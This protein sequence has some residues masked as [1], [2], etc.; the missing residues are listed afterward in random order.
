MSTGGIGLARWQDGVSRGDLGEL[1]AAGHD[2]R[3]PEEGEEVAAL[4]FVADGQAAVFE[5]P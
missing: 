4:A 1:L 5:E 3:E 2:C